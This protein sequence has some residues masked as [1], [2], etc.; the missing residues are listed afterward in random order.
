MRGANPGAIGALIALLGCTVSPARADV[1]AC[2][3][4]ETPVAKLDCLLKYSPSDA[5]G[6]LE[7]GKEFETMRLFDRAL[8]D[9]T[10]AIELQ[11]DNPVHYVERGKAYNDLAFWNEMGIKPYVKDPAAARG[12]G[13]NAVADYT[14][15]IQIDPRNAETYLLRAL[16]YQ[17]A[18]RD[19]QRAKTDFREVLRLK[20]GDREAQQRLDNLPD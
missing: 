9:L 18:L 17:Y 20:P 12:H 15:A 7:R 6:Y 10:K 13:M 4:A 5:K 16:A 11:P 2:A 19:N 8:A 3:R 1:A 14:K